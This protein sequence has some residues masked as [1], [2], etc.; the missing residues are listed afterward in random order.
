M[1]ER[2]RHVIVFAC[3]VCSR[4]FKTRSR[5][6]RHADEAHGLDEPVNASLYI[7]STATDE[8]VIRSLFKNLP[9]EEKALIP[10]WIKEDVFTLDRQTWSLRLKPH[11]MS[12]DPYIQ[13]E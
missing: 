2:A 3:P 5:C 11:I 6:H 10:P 7:L 9:R 8:E 12:Q 13:I 4:G 1:L